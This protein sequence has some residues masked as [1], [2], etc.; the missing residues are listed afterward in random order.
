[1]HKEILFKEI[2]ETVLAFNFDEIT[3][4]RKKILKPLID[5]IQYN[6]D[7]QQ[8][9]RLNF[10]CTHNSRR[11]HLSQVWAQT[12]AHYYGIKSV[13][14]YSGGTETTALF[15]KVAETLESSG[16]L[17]KK[18]SDKKNPIYAIKFS[19]NESP[20]IGFSKTYDN[21][22]N[23]QKEF[24]AIMTCS[25]ADNG[26]PFI[27]GA[28]KRIP[29]T[30]DDPKAFDNTPHQSQKYKERSLQIATEMFYV[31]SQIKK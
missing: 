15:P 8:S 27:A 1:M 13:F 29:I 4:D 22:F 11:S 2:Q 19:P 26:C 23:P 14:C 5:F 10:I 25:Q 21:Y 3:L 17:I 12:A 31:F 16:F 20:I 30:Y 24:A 9:I 18:I 7:I 6:T 28:E